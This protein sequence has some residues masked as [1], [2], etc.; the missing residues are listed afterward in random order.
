MTKERSRRTYI[1]EESEKQKEMKIKK[2]AKTNNPNPFTYP[3]EGKEK[4]LSTK[5]KIPSISFVKSSRSTFTDELIKRET[6]KKL[7]GAG[8]YDYE[9]AE[10]KVFKPMRKR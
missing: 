5:P 7:P 3:T 4:V 2:W 6:K 1:K 8:T 9:K 10:A